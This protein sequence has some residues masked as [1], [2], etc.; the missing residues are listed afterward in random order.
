MPRTLIRPRPGLLLC[1]ERWD[2]REIVV[3]DGLRLTAAPRSVAFAM[4]YAPHIWAATAVLDMAAYH[5]VVSIE[6]VGQW[7][8]L[9]PSYTGIEQSRC[10][11]DLADENAWSPQEVFL[12]ASPGPGPATT[13]RSRTVRS[14][15]STVGTSAR[16]DV[17]D[18]RTGVAGEYEGPLHLAG[19]RRALD[20]GSRASVQDPRSGAGH[21][22]LG[23]PEEPGRSSS[24]CGLPIGKPSVDRSPSADGPWSSRRGGS[25]PSRW[26]S[27][28][29]SRRTNEKSGCG[30]VSPRP[31]SWRDSGRP[32]APC[33]RG[34][35]VP[36]VCD[37]RDPDGRPTGC[38]VGIVA[39]VWHPAHA[40]GQS[41]TFATYRAAGP[42]IRAAGTRTGTAGRSVRRRS[43]PWGRS[44]PRR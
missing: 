20:L 36:N 34:R 21:D 22:G 44:G 7:I 29:P 13:N 42:E 35:S 16:P 27:V 26:L 1:N 5:D 40:G 4:R 41:Q 9:H 43:R 2:W 31:S 14:S 12:C 33:P 28:V 3:V 32:L 17:F 19:T 10:G 38:Q 18:P 6:E 8:D 11:R 15:T 25:R 24:G 37:Y 39:D 30:T 23:G